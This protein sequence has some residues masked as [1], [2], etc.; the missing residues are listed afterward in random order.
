MQQ[1]VLYDTKLWSTSHKILWN[2][3]LEAEDRSNAA[4]N[5]FGWHLAFTVMGLLLES[6]VLVE[7]RGGRGRQGEG[8]HGL[9]SCVMSHPQPGNIYIHTGT[10]LLETIPL[11]SSQHN[12]HSGQVAKP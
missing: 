1:N 6:A 7:M 11:H 5:E 9:P 8:K 10:V 4:A 3:Y 12:H 2:L